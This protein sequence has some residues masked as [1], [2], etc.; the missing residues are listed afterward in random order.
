MTENNTETTDNNGTTMTT[1][2][3]IYARAAVVLL[4]LNFCLTGYVVLNLNK[5]TQ[6]QIESVSQANSA[7]P[8]PT[9]RTERKVQ[10]PP[11]VPSPA[12]TTGEGSAFE[13]RENNN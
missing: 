7:T 3:T 13:T 6:E 1:V 5:T 12:S 2:K 11:A 10:P 9:G 4:A 8:T